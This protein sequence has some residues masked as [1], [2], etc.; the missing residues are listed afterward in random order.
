MANEYHMFDKEKDELAQSMGFDNWNEYITLDT[1]RIPEKE[2]KTMLR[3]GSMSYVPDLT[4]SEE[5]RYNLSKLS[6]RCR[7]RL[8]KGFWQTHPELLEDIANF[9]EES[10]NHSS[11]HRP[12][13]PSWNYTTAEMNEKYDK[14]W[15]TAQI[16]KAY[17]NNKDLLSDEE[18]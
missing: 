2:T 7:N 9:R 13:S 16:T 4:L 17:H 8:E 5:Q 10:F 18:E 3:D 6:R 11:K 15:T 1:S 14:D 12:N